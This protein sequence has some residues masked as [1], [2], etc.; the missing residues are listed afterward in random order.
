MRAG[1]AAVPRG[2]ASRPGR[3][4]LC[5]LALGVLLAGCATPVPKVMIFESASAAQRK[6]IV[7]PAPPDIPR[8]AWAGQLLG[9]VNFKAVGEKKVG[10]MDVLRWIVGLAFGDAPPVQVQRPQSGAVDA[11]GRI[12]VTDAGNAAVFVFDRVD[13]VLEVWNKAEG[14]ANFVSPVGIALGPGGDILVADSQLGFVTRLD[15]GGN[16]RRGIGR[17][18]LKRPTGLAYD[19]LGKR[20]YVSDTAEHDIKV[21]DDDG[22][23]LKSIG[24]RGE[25]KGEFNFPTHIA[26]ARGE[27]YVADTLNSRIQVLSDEGAVV[28][29]SFGALGTS[30]GNLVRPK[31]VAVDGEGN[32]YVVESYNDH[33]RVFNRGGELLLA[34]GGNGQDAGKF[35]LPA[36]VWID[37]GNRVFVADMFNARVAIFQFIGG[38]EE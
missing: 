11:A 6:P 34:I 12:Y 3:A 31:G 17:G 7:W 25:E 20:I 19:P 22:R 9:E 24:R 5:V 15:A 13:G 30:V 16:P 29:R 38:S 2:G 4:L 27:L 14:L 35:E 18:V 8:Y 36:G 33:L 32:I 1:A 28:K 10:V 23:L 26:F 37:S 21:F